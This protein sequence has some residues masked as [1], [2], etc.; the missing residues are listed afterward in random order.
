MQVVCGVMAQSGDSVPLDPHFAG[1][2]SLEQTEEGL[3]HAGQP[4]IES[5]FC[6]A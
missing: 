2:T 3:R 6:L 5:R 4:L 1:V